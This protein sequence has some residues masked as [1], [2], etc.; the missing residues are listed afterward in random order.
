MRCRYVFGF[1]TNA[2]RTLETTRITSGSASGQATQTVS[3][4]HGSGQLTDKLDVR[5]DERYSLYVAGQDR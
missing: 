4:P 1:A 5:P 3:E 2:D